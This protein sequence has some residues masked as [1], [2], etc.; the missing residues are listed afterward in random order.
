[1]VAGIHHGGGHA[2]YSRDVLGAGALAALLCAAV[3]EVGQG[4]APTG[5]QCAHALGAVELVAGEAQHVDVLLLDVDV[6]MAD[7]LHRVGVEEDTGLLTHSANLGDGQDGT[8]LVVGIHD[9]DQTGV[10]A[11]G[12]A[13]LLGGDVVTFLHIQIVGLAA[14]GG[15]GDLPGLAAKAL[16]HRGAGGIQSFFSFLTHGVEAGGVAVDFIEIGQHGI[17]GRLAHGGGCCVIGVDVHI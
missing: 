1:M 12:V 6:Q 2:A 8:D 10:G 13:N 7:G 16:G 5:V 17:D 3:D 14:A 9:G 11:D 4:N 15:E